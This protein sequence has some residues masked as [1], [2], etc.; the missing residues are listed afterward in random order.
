MVQSATQKALTTS[1]G[2]TIPSADML[3]SLGSYGGFQL[4]SDGSVA[5]TVGDIS[6]APDSG[7][8]PGTYRVSFPSA[9]AQIS[10]IPW[11]EVNGFTPRAPGTAETATARVCGYN[12]AQPS[13]Q[14]Y[15]T[16]QIA[17][18]SSNAVELP[19]AGFVVG[20]RAAFMLKNP[21]AAL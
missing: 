16:I 20:I 5:S 18:L 4:N 19:P 3:G 10:S 21:P 15:V 12:I 7:G 8:T 2:G 11:F 13:G 6:V 17:A 1:L 9:N 14:W